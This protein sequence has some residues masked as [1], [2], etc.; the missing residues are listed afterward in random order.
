MKIKGVSGAR[1]RRE[2]KYPLVVI[3]EEG[4][5]REIVITLRGL[6]FGFDRQWNKDLP[7]PDPPLKEK[8]DKQGRVWRK[9]GTME[10]IMEPDENDPE[11]K[12]RLEY[13]MGLRGVWLIKRVFDE[14]GTIQFETKEEDC[15][16][17]EQYYERIYQEL[18]EAG[19]P[20]GTIAEI[21]NTILRLSGFNID[22]ATR[23]ARHFFSRQ[24]A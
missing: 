4:Q 19:F 7:L 15:S 20:A 9:P 21:A 22:E 8:K 17:K 13:M 18:I 16:S 23:K 6:L 5:E 14:D 3:D 2:V 10:P 24:G 11:Y 12:E 1:L